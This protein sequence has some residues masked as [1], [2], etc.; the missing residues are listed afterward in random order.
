MAARRDKRSGT[1]ETSV[2][3]MLVERPSSARL[4]L[5]DHLFDSGRRRDRGPATRGSIGSNLSGSTAANAPLTVAAL[6][7]C[8]GLAVT[9]LGVVRAWWLVAVLGLPVVLYGLAGFRKARR[10]RKL[11]RSGAIAPRGH[12]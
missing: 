3:F 10:R 9:A 5:P 7:I 4:K 11:R 6:W 12:R 2:R 1:G 8:A